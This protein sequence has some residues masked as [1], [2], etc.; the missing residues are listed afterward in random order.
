MAFSQGWVGSSISRFAG[1]VALG[2]GPSGKRAACTVVAAVPRSSQA[3]ARAKTCARGRTAVP[4][5]G[6]TVHPRGRAVGNFP[7]RPLLAVQT[8]VGRFAQP[9]S[10]E[11]S[12]SSYFMLRCPAQATKEICGRKG[13]ARQRILA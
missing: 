3:S 7:W 12:F 9:L 2:S 13:Q 1:G 6:V 11:A 10:A 5:F 4:T 8:N